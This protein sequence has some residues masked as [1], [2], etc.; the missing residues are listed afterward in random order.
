MI[1]KLQGVT[2]REKLRVG[3]SAVSFLFITF[4]IPT[5]EESKQ[6]RILA[7]IPHANQF[8]NYINYSNPKI[9]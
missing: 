9:F 3:L 1:I 7:A 5:E 8:Q 6:K 2:L 4:V